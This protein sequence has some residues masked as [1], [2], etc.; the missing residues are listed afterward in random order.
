MKF[1]QKSIDFKERNDMFFFPLLLLFITLAFLLPR[2]PTAL[3]DQLKPGGRLI[4]PVGSGVFGQNLEQIDK[5]ADGTTEKKTLMSVM[6]VPLTD[7]ERQWNG[8]NRED[9]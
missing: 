4:I 2:L 7:A 5:K 1:F 6:F 8:K 9:L 3:V